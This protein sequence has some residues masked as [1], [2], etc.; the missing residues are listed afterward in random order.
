MGQKVHPIG[1]RLG[2]TKKH[3]ATWYAEE[4]YAEYLYND[5]LVREHIHK[6]AANAMI[7]RIEIERLAKSVIISVHTP[8]PGILIGKKG[9][10]ID[11]LK[12]N[13]PRS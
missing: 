10:G 2:I 1:I 11:N 7:S 4:D 13:Y 6:E 8:R 3:T 9:E 12:N 5:F